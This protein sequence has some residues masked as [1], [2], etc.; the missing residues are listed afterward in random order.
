MS[1]KIIVGLDVDTIDDV[2][3]IID[4]CPKCVW[5]KVGSQLFTR[6]GHQSIFLLKEKGKKIF[7]DLK[8]HDIPNT[9]K[10]AVSAARDLEVDMLTVHALGGSQM[11]KY[12][13][14]TVAGTAV[15]IIAVTIL[16]SHTEE[17][18]H[19]EL[20][21]AWKLGDAVLNLAN[22][23]LSVGAHGIVCSPMEISLLREKLGNDFLLI[24]PGVRPA[25]AAETHDQSR[26]M[27]PSE[28]I[29][30]GANML[31]LARPI[32]KANNPQA[33]F[34]RIVEEIEDEQ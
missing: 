29:I 7:L 34:D 31:V 1:D 23:A 30:L 20:G 27:T 5:F 22:M 16:T 21:I 25:W 19:K 6:C 13:S 11:I 8:Y 15:K 9:V 24:T 12:A 14:E 4:L 17:Q 3:R 2:K 28:A 32:L 26:V 18:I 10:N 33:A